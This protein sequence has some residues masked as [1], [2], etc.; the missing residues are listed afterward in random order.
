ME[1]QMKLL[2]EQLTEP[3]KKRLDERKKLVEEKKRT[4]G[5]KSKV[6]RRTRKETFA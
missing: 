3:E 1:E 6:S 2:V 5:S 4:K